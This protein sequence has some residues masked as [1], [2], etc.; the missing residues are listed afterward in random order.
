MDSRETNN[1]IKKM[2]TELNKGFSTE[3]YEMAE[4]LLKKYSPS[5]VIMEL[6]VITNL[7]FHM[8][9]AR[10]VTKNNTNNFHVR[11]K[12]KQVSRPLLIVGV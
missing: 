5:L 3:V 8:K 6:Q 10:M 9:H 4:M 1:P 2:D 11:E 7:W 12:I